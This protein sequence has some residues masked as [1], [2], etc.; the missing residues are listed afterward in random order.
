MSVR[1]FSCGASL[2]KTLMSSMYAVAE[3]SVSFVC[4]LRNVMFVLLLRPYSSERFWSVRN[5][6][7]LKIFLTSDFNV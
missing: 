6:N 5:K 4:L 1:L 2:S 7:I 3:S